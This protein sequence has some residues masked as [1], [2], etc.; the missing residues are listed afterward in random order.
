MTTVGIKRLLSRLPDL[1]MDLTIDCERQLVRL[2]MLEFDS[3][4]LAHYVLDILPREHG[5][6]AAEDDS[7]IDEARLPR[8]PAY[9]LVVELAG[10]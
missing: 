6:V 4:L 1:T 8:R 10:R 9:R 7:D 3:G 5:V 2:A